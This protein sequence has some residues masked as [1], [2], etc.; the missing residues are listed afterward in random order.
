MNL[1]Q[2]NLKIILLVVMDTKWFVLNC[3][4]IQI[5]RDEN[6]VY[7]LISKI[8]EKRKYCKKIMKESFEKELIITKEKERNFQMANKCH[9]CNNFYSEKGTR[10]RHK[11]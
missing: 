2:G 9:I 6:L 8:L 3:E 1:I 5:Y 7:K 4:T 11:R 10:L